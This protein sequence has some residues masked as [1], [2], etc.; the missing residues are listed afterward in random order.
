MSRPATDCGTA[1]TMASFPP[2]RLLPSLWHLLS[3]REESQCR[4]P[5][6]FILMVS[7]VSKR[8]VH[9]RRAT[10]PSTAHTLPIQASSPLF[11]V[12]DEKLSLSR[13][14][15]HLPSEGNRRQWRPES[16]QGSMQPAGKCPRSSLPSL[17]LRPLILQGLGFLALKDIDFLKKK[18]AGTFGS[19]QLY[20]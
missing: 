5:K 4:T 9:T 8:T 12:K 17:R 2:L 3:P 14:K 19:E 1:R 13:A 11:S 18:V 20:F 7:G 6:N 16:P 15:L 10:S